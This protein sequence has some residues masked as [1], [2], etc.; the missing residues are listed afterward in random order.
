M[1]SQPVNTF[2]IHKSPI[3]IVSLQSAWLWTRRFVNYT[4]YVILFVVNNGQSST[5]LRQ[6]KGHE[7]DISTQP[8]TDRQTDR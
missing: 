1:F 8:P 6:G 3:V 5:Q 4:L 2:I 7:P